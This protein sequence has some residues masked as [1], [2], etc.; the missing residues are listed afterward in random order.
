[1]FHAALLLYGLLDLDHWMYILL[2][3]GLVWAC[4][5][6]NRSLL[7]FILPPSACFSYPSTTTRHLFSLRWTLVNLY[8]TCIFVGACVVGR[9]YV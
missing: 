3:V 5:G 7:V 1:V 9:M 6:K 2:V 4:L 8:Q